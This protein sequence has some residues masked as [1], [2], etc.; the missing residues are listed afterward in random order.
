MNNPQQV[1]KELELLKALESIQNVDLTTICNETL[2]KDLDGHFEFIDKSFYLETLILQNKN[3]EFF[4]LVQSQ[5]Y[6]TTPNMLLLATEKDNFGIFHL[7]LK[8][9]PFSPSTL[10]FLNL[11]LIKS[12]MM[13]RPDIFAKVNF[14]RN[15]FV[16]CLKI[17]EGFIKTNLSAS[18]DTIKFL[19]EVGHSMFD[20]RCNFIN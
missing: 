19:I 14:Y 10:E 20:L 15:V 17:L 13:N 11:C 16:D 6:P 4:L 18:D 8:K 9:L 5:D 7:L 3:Q 2:F 12:R 1:R